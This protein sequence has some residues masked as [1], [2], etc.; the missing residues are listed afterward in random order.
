MNPSFLARAS[1]LL[2]VQFGLITFAQAAPPDLTNGGSPTSS[3]VMDSFQ[4]GGCRI[5]LT[6]GEGFGRDLRLVGLGGL[7]STVMIHKFNED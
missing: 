4:S 1:H 3:A 5:G 6:W 2:V 7:E